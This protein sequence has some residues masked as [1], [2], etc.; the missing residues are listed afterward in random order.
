MHQSDLFVARPPNMSFSRTFCCTVTGK[1]AFSDA[2]ASTSRLYP[3]IWFA[4]GSLKSKTIRPDWDSGTR[5][6]HCGGETRKSEFDSVITTSSRR[7]SSG[8]HA[9]CDSTYHEN[10]CITNFFRCLI[11][12]CFL[13]KSKQSSFV[14]SQTVF[15]IST[16]AV[17]KESYSKLPELAFRK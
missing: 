6:M 11:Q 8:I 5:C 15:F 17:N 7:S 14:N 4:I 10:L 16:C 2:W 13:M 12:L 1:N 9:T 3:T